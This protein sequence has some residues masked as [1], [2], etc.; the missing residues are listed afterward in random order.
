[1][2]ATFSPASIRLAT[3]RSTAT[4]AGPLLHPADLEPV[5][6][7]GTH[8][9]ALPHLAA[10]RGLDPLG[11]V[12]GFGGRLHG[13]PPGLLAAVGRGEVEPPGPRPFDD[14][15]VLVG[16]LDERFEVFGPPGES[17]HGIDQ[18]AASWPRSASA[19]ISF[20]C[21]RL[22]PFFHADRLGSSNTSRLPA[23]M[24]RLAAR[25]CTARPDTRTSPG[26]RCGLLRE[27]GVRRP[28]PRR[29]R[30]RALPSGE[31]PGHQECRSTVY[32]RERVL[33]R[34]PEGNTHPLRHSTENR[35][36]SCPR[37]AARPCLR[38]SRAANPVGRSWL[39]VLTA[40]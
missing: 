14:Q 21:G 1:M 37:V 18:D 38:R 39:L 5:R 31:P 8:R 24:P 13:H 12:V 28:R 33:C 11:R 10:Q 34:A 7:P 19:I 20:H 9:L 26:R 30:V 2:C 27:P 15:A 40:A 25:P 23:G 17:V 35:S 29:A 4:S 32:Q 22:T 16:Q 3:S 36:G 6:P